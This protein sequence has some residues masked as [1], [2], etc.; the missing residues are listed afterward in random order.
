MATRARRSI[1]STLARAAIG[2]TLSAAALIMVPGEASAQAN[3]AAPPW[4]ACGR[5]TPE[6]KVVRQFPGGITLRCGGPLGEDPRFGYRHIVARHRTNFEDM[7]AGTGTFQNWRD[8][9]D[10]AIESI[11]IDPDT[12]A[13]APGKQVCLSRVV[14]LHSLQTGQLVRQ[15]IVVMY[16]DATTRDV[17]TVTPRD[18]QC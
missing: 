2:L 16:I 18:K 7:A 10:F 4:G 15:Q 8:V 11:A 5:S 3:T 6:D 13:P 14:F 17:R 9:A 1:T 12:T